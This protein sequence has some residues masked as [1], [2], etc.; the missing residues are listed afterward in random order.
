MIC[1]TISLIH[2]QVESL[3][4][5]GLNAIAV[6]PQ[7]QTEIGEETEALT[8]LIYTMP[9]YFSNKLK[10]RLSASNLLKV[11]VIDEAISF[12]ESSFP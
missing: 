10:D 6:G 5:L 4:G 7:Q 11:I 12:P 2:S 3:T 1:P 8:S 9:E